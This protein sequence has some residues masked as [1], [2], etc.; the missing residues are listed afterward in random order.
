MLF[1]EE[2]KCSIIELKNPNVNASEHLSQ[3]DFYANLI[4]N[5]T[6]S[7]F[8]ISTFYGYLIGEKIESRD[9][10]GRVS[11]YEHSYHL[12]TCLDHLQK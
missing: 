12:I 2:G 5:Y 3:I 1:P 7:Q 6:N 8:T 11:A 10:L 4:L 9:V